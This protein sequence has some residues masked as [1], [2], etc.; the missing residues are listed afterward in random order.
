MVWN[1]KKENLQNE[2]WCISLYTIVFAKYLEVPCN[3][4]W[5]NEIKSVQKK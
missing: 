5:K 4:L 1:E 3:E 2:A